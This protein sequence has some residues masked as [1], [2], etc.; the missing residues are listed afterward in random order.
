MTNL[1]CLARRL[2]YPPN[3]GDQGHSFHLLTHWAG[4]D[5]AHPGRSL[6]DPDVDV[7]LGV[8]RA[9][10]G[11]MARLASRAA[12][13]RSRL[14]GACHDIGIDNGEVSSP[15]MAGHVFDMTRPW[16]RVDLVDPDAA[17]S[18]PF[19]ATRRWPISRRHRR[20]GERVPASERA[21]S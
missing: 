13:L 4:A 3:A 1:L 6:N 16:T 10:C 20:K 15:V 2:N 19:A 7:A 14:A 12:M 17:K 11:N 8:V 18:R 21:V 9:R 5:R